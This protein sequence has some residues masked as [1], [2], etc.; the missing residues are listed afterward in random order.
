MPIEQSGGDVGAMQLTGAARR[1]WGS[2]TE[3]A[4][5][6]FDSPVNLAFTSLTHATSLSNVLQDGLTFM[7]MGA[8]ALSQDEFSKC[9]VQ[10]P[11]SSIS[12][13]LWPVLSFA[14]RY[15]VLFPFRLT[16]LLAASL[17]FFSALPLVVNSGR[18]DWQRWIFKVYCNAFLL[19][20]G[21]RIKHNSRK[22]VLDVP[23]LFVSNHTSVIDY[24][25]LSAHDF[26]HATIAQTHSG[27]LGMFEHSV[28]TLN[29]SLMFNRNEKNDRKLIA[30]KMRKHVH[31]TKNVP[32]L[33]FPE[34]TC[35]NNEYT[36]LFHKGAFELDATIVP[37]AIKYDKQWA[38]A[39]WHSKTQ[40][41]TYHILYLMT[42]WALVADVSYLP[43]QALQTGET[44]TDFANKVKANISKQ[45]GL[46]NLS[47]DGYFKNFQPTLEKQERLKEN[48]QSRYGALLSNRLRMGLK[49]YHRRDDGGM[50]RLRRSNSFCMGDMPIWHAYDRKSVEQPDWLASNETTEAKNEI[51]M[52]LLDEER[53]NDMI[54]KISDKKND[55]V[56]VWKSY[57]KEKGGDQQRRIENSSWRL[58]FKQK[59]ERD[60]QKAKAIATA[61]AEAEAWNDKMSP[62][63]DSA[64]SPRLGPVLE[65]AF[66]M[67]S[68]LIGLGLSEDEEDDLESERTRSMEQDELSDVEEDFVKRVRTRRTSLSPPRYGHPLV[69]AN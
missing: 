47:W 27:L 41:F 68:H 22:P 58:W 21:S 8:Q 20:W 10:G 57:T 16:L 40:S 12:L 56:N 49:A 43:P 17:L 52:Q 53:S 63:M 62:Q 48:P 15:F 18:E 24:I 54:Q 55:V 38:D 28:L 69:S 4:V 35:V 3:E 5:R 34:G 60:M 67:V 44:S 59:I 7:S 29:G 51:L 50:R 26:P 25:V 32:L 13:H 61:I 37:V 19:S 30:A 64:L 45:A 31:N 65:N 14:I 9:F 36:V 33:I 66:N 1:P 46:R 23:H 39:Y 6:R 2:A 42:R 11:R